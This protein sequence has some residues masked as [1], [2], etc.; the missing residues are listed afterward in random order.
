MAGTGGSSKK[1]DKKELSKMKEILGLNVMEAEQQISGYVMV[2][3]NPCSY[4]GDIRLLRAI[5]ENDERF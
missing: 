4:P 5:D 3:K 2:T 1:M